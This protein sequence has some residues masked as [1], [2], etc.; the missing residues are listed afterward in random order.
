MS[1]NASSLSFVFLSIVLDVATFLISVIEHLCVDGPQAHQ[2]GDDL[3]NEVGHDDV[4]VVRE[5]LASEDT[6]GEHDATN[7]EADHQNDTED[8]SL[9]QISPAA[10]FVLADA[11]VEHCAVD[12]EAQAVNK[13]QQ[14]NDD[15]VNI[16]ENVDGSLHIFVLRG[17]LFV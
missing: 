14:R 15:V 9:D 7:G 11:A 3:R 4:E 12:E 8:L 16:V 6:V 2:S 1:K 10:A 5:V 17:T 13:E